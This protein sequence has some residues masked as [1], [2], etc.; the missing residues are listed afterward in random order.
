MFFGVCG[1]SSPKPCSLVWASTFPNK[2]GTYPSN[3]LPSK[4]TIWWGSSDATFSFKPPIISPG[5]SFGSPIVG[6]FTSLGLGVSQLDTF[7][8]NSHYTVIFAKTVNRLNIEYIITK[9]DFQT[10]VDSETKI[11]VGAFDRND[12]TILLDFGSNPQ[13]FNEYLFEVIAV[14]DSPDIVKINNQ[15]QLVCPHQVR[16]SHRLNNPPQ[17]NEGENIRFE[18]ESVGGI[19][20]VTITGRAIN[21]N[22]ENIPR[23]TKNGGFFPV[24]KNTFYAS[25]QDKS[26]Q[27]ASCSFSVEIVNITNNESEFKEID[28]SSVASAEDI[29]FRRLFEIAI[30]TDKQRFS[31][32]LLNRFGLE[33]R[34]DN[35]RERTSGILDSNAQGD[36]TTPS[37][38]DGSSK[39]I[40]ININK[41]NEKGKKLEVGNKIYLSYIGIVKHYIR[42]RVDVKWAITAMGLPVPQA[43]AYPTGIKVSNFRFYEWS[44]TE[45]SLTKEIKK[46]AGWR[47]VETFNATPHHIALYQEQVCDF[48]AGNPSVGIINFDYLPG[49]VTPMQLSEYIQ[50]TKLLPTFSVNFNE[51]S[52]SGSYHLN[53]ATPDYQNTEW[54][55]NSYGNDTYQETIEH[56]LFN[57]HKRTLKK[58][59][60]DKWGI[61]SNMALEIEKDVKAKKLTAVPFMDDPDIDNIN[62][63]PPDEKIGTLTLGNPIL[64][65][66]EY[67]SSKN[68]VFDPFLPLSKYSL[69]NV[70]CTAGVMGGV[71]LGQSGLGDVIGMVSVSSNIITEPLEKETR[72]LVERAFTRGQRFSYIAIQG[73]ARTT[74]V[75][76]ITCVQ[77]PSRTYSFAFHI[78]EEGFICFN[79]FSTSYLNQALTNLTYLPQ[80]PAK[81]PTNESLPRPSEFNTLVGYNGILGDC[82]G[83]VPGKL[84]TTSAFV[85][86]DKFY[87]FTNA[88][89]LPGIDISR[90]FKI[91][92]NNITIND[93]VLSV[94]IPS[95]YYGRTCIYYLNTGASKDVIF[96]GKAGGETVV[97]IDGLSILPGPQILNIDHPW[98]NIDQ[99]QIIANESLNI[100]IKT[101]IFLNIKDNYATDFLAGEDNA[102]ISVPSE[103][104][105]SFTDRPVLFKSNIISV[106]EDKKSNIFLFFNDSDN[107]I[108]CVYTNDFGLSWIYFYGIIEQM[109]G[110]PVRDPFVINFIKGNKCFIFYRFLNKIMCKPVAF[111]WFTEEDA[112]LVEPNEKVYI[113]SQDSTKPSEEK[114]GSYSSDGTSLRRHNLSFI[115]AGDITDDNFIKLTKFHSVKL[116]NKDEQGKEITETVSLPIQPLAVGNTTVFANQDISSQYFSGYRR[117]NGEMRLFFLGRA[118]DT[119]GGGNQLQCNFSIDDGISWFD[120]WEYTKYGWKRVKVDKTSNTQFIERPVNKSDEDFELGINLH[121]TK[122]GD[123]DIVNIIEAP[124]VFHQSSTKD[125]FIFYFYEKCLLCKMFNE[126][127][128]GEYEDFKFNV[129]NKQSFFIDGYLLDGV[130]SQEINKNVAFP[131]NIKGVIQNFNEEREVEPQRICAY[132]LPNG[133]VRVFYKHKNSVQ[134]HAAIYNGSNWLLE[135]M[136]Y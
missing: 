11:N 47:V 115:V 118:S 33:Y 111:T 63:G 110:E 15:L 68:C 109:D 113:I 133:N 41:P 124:Y 81:K 90:I 103:Y 86:S 69:G 73:A 120:L 54:Y 75:K 24:G 40:E 30:P 28:I 91:E 85:E 58:R 78:S 84:I 134:L 17:I 66:R 9:E 106:A 61:E 12:G 32:I 43:W 77:D 101:V 37:Y 104:E 45:D 129:E 42:Q 57:V 35:G 135:D 125:I 83:Y 108:S 64:G 5:E 126:S 105:A 36:L 87:Y 130:V 26:G 123:K 18:I 49:I 76:S 102:D 25:G 116:Y 89:E 59:D 60:L 44:L 97:S 38:K 48:G 3:L 62:V 93:N 80:L 88:N 98:I 29:L 55:K 92:Q 71:L 8:T 121:K 128:M 132:D 96:L 34:L 1:N 51:N 56:L 46:I 50:G 70:E 72:I 107:G 52:D 53:I 14:T 20:Q 127:I 7:T 23:I 114:S 131:Y 117:D 4:R 10:Y 65:A 13:L 67:L 95:G 2:I 112:F 100:K 136:L 119:I 82:I 74:D 6:I 94:T 21:A 122:V 27:T 19:G 16:K 79:S 31:K 22:R 39:V 99:I